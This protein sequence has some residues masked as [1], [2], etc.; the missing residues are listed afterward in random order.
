MVKVKTIKDMRNRDQFFTKEKITRKCINIVNKCIDIIKPSLEELSI[1]EPS[2]GNGDFYYNF[3][4]GNNFAFDIEKPKHIIDQTYIESDFLKVPWLLPDTIYI[5]NPPFGKSGKLA[6]DFIMK[7]IELKASIIAFILPPNINS[8]ARMDL[9]KE[10]GYSLIYHKLLPSDSF[11]FYNNKEVIDST[12]ES[13]FQI[14]IKTEYAEM[15]D[16]RNIDTIKLKN[17]SHVQVYTINNNVIRNT[18]RDTDG[19]EF[20]QDGIGK[21]WI[22][23]CDFYLPLRVFNSNGKPESYNTFDDTNMSNVGF[24]VICADKNIKDKIVI[25]NCYTLVTNKINIAKKQLILKEIMRVHNLEKG[26]E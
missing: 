12:A 10:S 3:P 16:I 7:C 15:Y 5:G 14:Y 18:N 13:V 8:K 25:E 20:I 6:F 11:Y 17:N 1:V 2:A 22:G 9:I 19:V 24:G 21:Q 23:G 26:D 4:K